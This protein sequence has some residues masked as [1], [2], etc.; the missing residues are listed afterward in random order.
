MTVIKRFT[1]RDRGSVHQLLKKRDIFTA[2][3][4]EVALSVLDEHINFPG[5]DDYEVL[6]AFNDNALLGYICFGPIPM[7]DR[8]FDLYWI[9]VGE[10]YSRRGIGGLLV[11]AMEKNLVERGAR[12]IYIDTSSTQPYDPARKFYHK[13]GYSVAAK[14]DD[15]YR[16]DDHK[17]IFVK[18]L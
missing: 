16:T 9:A 6:C 15:F 7:T 4:V 14:F 5:R 17:I 1:S 2:D 8:C 3:E 12:H 10:T 11:S 13:H 18:K